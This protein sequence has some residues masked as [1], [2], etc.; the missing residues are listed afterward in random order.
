MPSAWRGSCGWRTTARNAPSPAEPANAI[1]V[2]FDA[3]REGDGSGETAARVAGGL[4]E[5]RGAHL[6]LVSTYR[7][8]VS[9][10]DDA[11]GRLDAAAAR[12]RQGGLEVTAHLRSGEPADAVIDVAEEQAAAL[13]VVEP[14]A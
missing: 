12:L 8:I 1:V 10:R 3:D 9:D 2:E 7:P 5:A 6:H 14:G 13:I 4:A 11:A